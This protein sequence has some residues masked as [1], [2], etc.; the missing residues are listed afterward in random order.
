[1]PNNKKQRGRAQ[2]KAAAVL[3]RAQLEADLQGKFGTPAVDKLIKEMMPRSQQSTAASASPSK[4]SSFSTTEKDDGVVC[5]HGSSA[6]HFA[7]G[8][9]F[10]K[11]VKSFVS[12]IKKKTGDD[13]AVNKFKNDIENKKIMIDVEFTN[14]VF[15]M[16]VSLY[17]KLT[18]EE[19]ESYHRFQQTSGSAFMDGMKKTASY[20]L[21][22]ILKL[23]LS[24]KYDAIA[25]IMGEKVD[26]ER[27]AKYVRDSENERGIINCL[28][29]ET[30]NHCVCMAT[31]K[32]RANDMD[33]M[34]VCNGCLKGFPKAR[35]MICDGCMAVV[36]CR[37]NC[38]ITHWPFHKSYCTVTQEQLKEATK[39]NKVRRRKNITK[40][41]K[42]NNTTSVAAASINALF[43]SEASEDN[44][45]EPDGLVSL[46]QRCT[47]ASNRCG[48]GGGGKTKY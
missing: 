39:C 8:S 3:R 46:E 24:M 41:K 32:D 18:S 25:Q 35:T 36:Y 14:F 33:K 43:F 23:G 29:R 44:Q 17:L 27:L 2:K 37:E 9:P 31:D 34:V 15:A 4:P 13:D 21:E 47:T 26:Y 10:L 22:S 12:L 7:A 42:N 1:M 28:Y 19:K 30:K 40:T 6:K 48:S 20:E 5:Y 11:I 16:G 45:P 38:S